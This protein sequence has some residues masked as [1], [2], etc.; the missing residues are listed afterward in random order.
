M[1]ACFVG[2]PFKTDYL[3][4]EVFV[5]DKGKLRKFAF[6]VGLGVVEGDPADDDVLDIDG[7]EKMF[8]DATVN[9]SIPRE[10]PSLERALDSLGEIA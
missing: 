2:I 5:D 4:S 8:A 9:V 1:R 6:V 7:A 10:V 3:L